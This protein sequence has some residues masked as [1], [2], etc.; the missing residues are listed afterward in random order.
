MNQN[1]NLISIQDTEERIQELGMLSHYEKEI[2][3]IYIYI[4][5]I[6]YIKDTD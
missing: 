2:L 3:K 4:F 1:E 5:N 6:S